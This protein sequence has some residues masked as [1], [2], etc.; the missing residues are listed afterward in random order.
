MRNLHQRI[1]KL[2]AYQAQNI[3]DIPIEVLKRILYLQLRW[4]VDN[5]LNE[6]D[7][8]ELSQISKEWRDPFFIKRWF[9]PH[10]GE[11]NEV[12]LYLI[13]DMSYL[14]K[15]GDLEGDLIKNVEAY[16]DLHGSE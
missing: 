16:R 12:M 1:K 7:I 13:R 2:E 3:T 14:K 6:N 10:E 9:D 15:Y 5:D 8:T 4:Y 11:I